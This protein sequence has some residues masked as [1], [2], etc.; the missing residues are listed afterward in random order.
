MRSVLVITSRN[1]T[2]VV[3]LEAQVAIGKDTNQLVAVL[4]MGM[5]RCETCASV[6]VGIAH[7]GLLAEGDRIDDHPTPRFTR[8]TCSA[9]ASMDMFLWITPSPPWRAMAMASSDS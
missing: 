6:P 1:R 4:T 8:R 2:A 9:W 7:V 3:G 5:P